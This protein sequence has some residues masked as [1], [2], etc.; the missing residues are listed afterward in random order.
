ME[1][2]RKPQINF[3]VEPEFKDEINTVAEVTQ[4]PVAQ[5]CRQA[6]F[7]EVA[8]LKRTHPLLSEKREVAIQ[9]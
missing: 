2:K 5:I 8:E 3:E 6:V 7:K 1:N 9:A 4:I